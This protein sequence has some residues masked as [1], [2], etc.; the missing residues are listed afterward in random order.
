[1]NPFD[2]L[3]D[4]PL[5]SQNDELVDLTI[6]PQNP[7]INQ[8]EA[9]QTYHSPTTHHLPT[10][11]QQ[12][13]DLR[14]PQSVISI[15]PAQLHSA[16]R[17]VFTP[18]S[19]PLPAQF[20]PQAWIPLPSYAILPPPQGPSVQTQRT[21]LKRAAVEDISLTKKRQEIAV[22]VPS[23]L[24]PSP[25]VQESYATT[26][27]LTYDCPKTSKEGREAFQKLRGVLDSNLTLVQREN[28]ENIILRRKV[29]LA[30]KM[31]SG[32]TRQAL[33][34]IFQPMWSK[35][36]LSKKPQT[37][38]PSLI[39][40][41]K[42]LFATWKTEI[43]NVNRWLTEAGLGH[44]KINYSTY[45]TS[46]SEGARYKNL[47]SMGKTNTHICFVTYDTLKMKE[48]LKILS[49]LPRT[50]GQRRSKTRRWGS[51]IFD[52]A[53]NLKS[54]E[55]DRSKGAVTFLKRSR[56]EMVIALTGTP[57]DNRLSDLCGQFALLNPK[58]FNKKWAEQF[59]KKV[60]E[61]TRLFLK[62]YVNGTLPDNWQERLFDTKSKFE[63][64]FR[65]VQEAEDIPDEDSDDES[66]EIDFEGEVGFE[67][68]RSEYD[69]LRKIEN[70]GAA[71]QYVRGLV[72]AYILQN[73]TPPAAAAT[74]A[75]TGEIRH[76]IRETVTWELSMFQTLLYKTYEEVYLRTPIRER[77]TMLF[78][79]T[80]CK[81][82]DLPKL[83][84]N[85]QSANDIGAYRKIQEHL[86]N[87]TLANV[88]IDEIPKVTASSE[89]QKI[90]ASGKLEALK[91]KILEITKASANNKIIVF[92]SL[93]FMANELV[94]ELKLMNLDPI[95]V[96]GS[97]DEKARSEAINEAKTTQNTAKSV[98]ILT[99]GIGSEGLCLPE[100][101]Y[102]INFDLPWSPN[103]LAQQIARID[104]MGQK[105]SVHIIGF[106]CTNNTNKIKLDRY[107]KLMYEVKTKTASSA[108]NPAADDPLIGLIPEVEIDFDAL[109]R[110]AME[111][112]E[113]E[114]KALQQ[115][116]KDSKE[117]KEKKKVELP[118]IQ[119]LI[120]QHLA[121]QDKLEKETDVLDE[122]ELGFY[123]PNGAKNAILDLTGFGELGYHSEANIK[124]LK[125]VKGSPQKYDDILIQDYLRNFID[126]SY[127]QESPQSPQS[128]PSASSQASL[129]SSSSSL[130]S[131]SESSS[132]SKD[133]ESVDG[134]DSVDGI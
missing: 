83:I 4:I 17:P 30:Q 75:S 134:A 81:V 126:L 133:E 36:L 123:E 35:I 20:Q 118:N 72:K 76:P 111:G 69:K 129:S 34:S 12:F 60:S 70:V 1:M 104:R 88:P 132:S 11:L 42:T 18:P 94:K 90:W 71:L 101:N 119:G 2:F 87:I 92:V 49:L 80:L 13:L 79:Q 37:F 78:I 67:E 15:S 46:A 100:F 6:P 51:V 50:D 86:Q 16:T 21:N 93:R 128:P 121:D 64:G 9:Q 14:Q 127:L 96:T 85:S 77:N 73:N 115:D 130:R 91:A 112:D 116:A 56:P 82:C 41:G 65:E 110:R 59:T 40:C 48:H 74:I 63:A 31:G 122:V 106:S 24:L 53:H 55:T 8:K 68:D 109:I 27:L 120:E 131:S 54:I 32:K 114:L 61:S 125:T 103:K 95:L 43:E 19:L 47:S 44:L 66:S 98:L 113:D 124:W 23:T 25:K 38:Y 89:Y 62:G 5:Y 39:V 97:L 26:S 58:L 57:V 33:I 102:I 99:E 10:S 45:V 29:L 107:F 7:P 52:E 84:E 28:I 22:A 117:E 108:L 3:S 105:R